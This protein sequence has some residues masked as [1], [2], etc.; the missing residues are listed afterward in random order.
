V[1]GVRGRRFWEGEGEEDGD[2]D[3][4]CGEVGE[5]WRVQLAVPGCG[6]GKRN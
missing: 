3:A 4:G 2:E 1:V 6:K 5:W